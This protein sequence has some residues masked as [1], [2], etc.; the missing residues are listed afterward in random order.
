MLFSDLSL[1]VGEF[2][3]AKFRWKSVILSFP[4]CIVCLILVHSR[5]Y[6]ICALFSYN[7]AFISSPAAYIFSGAQAELATVSSL[8]D[9]KRSLERMLEETTR[10]NMELGEYVRTCTPNFAL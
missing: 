1:T 10:E 2:S 5:P 9:Q 4:L 8:I 7:R 6:L 3:A